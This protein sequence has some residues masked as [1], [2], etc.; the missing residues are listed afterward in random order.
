MDAYLIS[1]DKLKKIALINGN[2]EDNII[3]VIIQRVQRTVLR[4]I[5]GTALYKRLLEGVKN[6]DLNAYEKE[7]LDD[8]IAPLM[9]VACDRK[10][11]NALTYEIRSKTVGKAQDEHIIPVNESEN[12]RLDNDIRQDFYTEK[13]TLKGYLVDNCE[14]FPEYKEFVHN[15]ENI[16][17]EKL[18]TGKNNVSFI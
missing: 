8:Y 6:S 12:L 15:K 9:S 10:S 7:L 13:S 16:P 1:A 18:K 14:N 2:V 17:P 11:I 3:N 4:P 5:L